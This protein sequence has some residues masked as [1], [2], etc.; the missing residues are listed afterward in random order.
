MIDIDIFGVFKCNVAIEWLGGFRF[1]L[2]LA[3][4][5]ETAITY[6]NVFQKKSF[7]SILLEINHT[8]R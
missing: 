6:M 7:L 5:R 3:H 1:F 2:H 8:T 4:C